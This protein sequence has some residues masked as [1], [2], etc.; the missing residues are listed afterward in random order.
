MRRLVVSVVLVAALALP[1]TALAIRAYK[2]PLVGVVLKTHKNV[3][4]SGGVSDGVPLQCDEGAIKTRNSFGFLGPK[5]VKD[6]RRFRLHTTATLV[7]ENIDDSG[8]VIS[9]DK[10]DFEVTLKGR[11]K[12]SFKRV[13]GT[14]IMNGSYF[15]PQASNGSDVQ[16]HHCAGTADWTAHKL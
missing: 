16:Y 10:A 14:V 2:G 9:R 13:S 5:R 6:N 12:R 1:A 3:I 4:K 7:F 11:F 15:G 8:Y